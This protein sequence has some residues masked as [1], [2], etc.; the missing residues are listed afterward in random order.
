MRV[1]PEKVE[2]KST[3]EPDDVA[4]ALE[5]LE[6]RLDD[7]DAGLTLIYF[8]DAHR[9]DGRLALDAHGLIVR[10]RWR[11]GR[12]EESNDVT[13]KLRPAS[14]DLSAHLSMLRRTREEGE[15]DKFEGDWTSDRRTNSYSRKVEGV[16]AASLARVAQHDLPPGDLLSRGQRA[17]VTSVLGDDLPTG[18]RCFAPVLATTWELDEGR[19]A[20]LWTLGA[21]RFLEISE[22]VEADSAE[23][24]LKQH[25]EYLS[26]L[27]VDVGAAGPKTSRV[28]EIASRVGTD[29]ADR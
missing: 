2:L 5:R 14:G 29:T 12:A 10:L 27:R 24:K 22:R 8:C 7:P 26:K 17:F 4:H 18:L 21:T 11:L 25:Q 3:V 16:R 9:P 28:L 15:D 1:E 19:S 20:E 6:L 23:R 13:V